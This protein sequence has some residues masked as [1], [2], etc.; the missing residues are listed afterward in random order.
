MPVDIQFLVPVDRRRAAHQPGVRGGA[1]VRRREVRAHPPVAAERAA[2]ADGGRGHRLLRDP[3]RPW[4]RSTSAAGRATSPVRDMESAA[5]LNRHV[6]QRPAATRR[7]V[8]GHN[9]DWPRPP[10]HENDPT[11]NPV[12][13][14]PQLLIHMGCRRLLPRNDRPV[15]QFGSSRIRMSIAHGNEYDDAVLPTF[16]QKIWTSPAG[17]GSPHRT[18]RLRR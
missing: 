5:P 4:H 9:N 18:P 17:L 14:M 15:V 8:R 2:A 6:L 13:D 3:T 11:A 1:Y 16:G 7:H 12:E 10:T